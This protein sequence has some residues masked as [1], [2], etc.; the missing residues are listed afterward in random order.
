VA[1]V[2]RLQ[3]V[4]LSTVKEDGD[5]ARILTSLEPVCRAHSVHLPSILKGIEGLT[6]SK[7]D[8]LVLAVSSI[9]GLAEKASVE[10]PTDLK[11]KFR[12]RIGDALK[13][14]IPTAPRAKK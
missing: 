5:R 6:S 9:I 11:S 12:S 13:G 1:T 10:I 4:E 3:L 7:H 14:A 2:V 8:G